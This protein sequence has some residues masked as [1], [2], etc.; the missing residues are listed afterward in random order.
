MKNV[1][2]HVHES[3]SPHMGRIERTLHDAGFN[4]IAHKVRTDMPTR[5]HVWGP[6]D[7]TA[8]RALVRAGC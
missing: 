2:I 4:V 8:V 1:V 6:D 7:K 5:Y 3:V